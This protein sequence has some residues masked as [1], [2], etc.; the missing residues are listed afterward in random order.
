MDGD[1]FD[2]DTICDHWGE[3]RGVRVRNRHIRNDHW[4]A[5]RVLGDLHCLHW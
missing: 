2:Y 4:D 1:L 5:H 3:S